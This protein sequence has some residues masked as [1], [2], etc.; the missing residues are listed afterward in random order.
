[1]EDVYRGSPPTGVDTS[2]CRLGM[3]PPPPSDPRARDED[4]DREDD[5]GERGAGADPSCPMTS[6]KTDQSSSSPAL[7]AGDCDG[8]VNLRMLDAT[9]C[10]AD[11]RRTG[12][13]IAA[14]P[15]A[16]I[17][18]ASARGED[19]VQRRGKRA[20][21]DTAVAAAAARAWA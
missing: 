9:R 6:P 7:E 21:P 14:V 8:L 10:N 11:G 15:L 12:I 13:V 17:R 16:R 19:V 4:G 20:R 5:R 18:S 1:M 2:T 3:A